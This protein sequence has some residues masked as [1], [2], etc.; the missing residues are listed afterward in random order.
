MDCF[1][2]QDPQYFITELNLLFRIPFETITLKFIA[3]H[4]SNHPNRIR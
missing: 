2:V 4:V 1:M 3:Q